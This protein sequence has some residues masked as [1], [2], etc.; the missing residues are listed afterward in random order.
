MKDKLKVASKEV[1][2]SKQREVVFGLE[3]KR[4]QSKPTKL[5]KKKSLWRGSMSIEV[6]LL[7]TR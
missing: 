3:N 4:N 1:S 6:S 5:L 2:F 7:K